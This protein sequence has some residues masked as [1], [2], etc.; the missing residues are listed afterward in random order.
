MAVWH[1]RGR[2]ATPPRWTPL[3]Q[4]AP[5]HGAGRHLGKH[6]SVNRHAA[7]APASGVAR[8]RPAPG[9][10][11]ALTPETL[12]ETRHTLRTPLNHIIG[13]SEMLLESADDLGL[14]E[15]VPDLQQ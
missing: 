6:M 3:R 13:Y 10:G 15:L 12:R 7:S 5:S 2:E 14:D 11:L 4:H 8:G 1:P 9:A